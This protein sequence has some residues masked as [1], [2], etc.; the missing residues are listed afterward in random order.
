[1]ASLTSRRSIDT[2]LA[3]L[4]DPAT[5]AEQPVLV[6]FIRALQAATSPEA[7]YRL[8]HDLLIRYLA[9]QRVREGDLATERAA[10]GEHFAGLVRADPKPVDEIRAVQARIARIEHTDRVM[11]ALAAHLRAIADGLVW[12]ATGYDRVAIATLSRGTR[13]DRLADDGVGLQAELAAL[14]ELWEEDHAFT[15]HN[16][17]T[18]ILRHGDLTTFRPEQRRVEIREIKAGRPA[19]PT[20]PQVARLSAAT[21]LINEAAAT[22]PETGQSITLHR[23][24]IAYRTSLSSLDDAIA[25]ARVEGYASRSISEMQ[26]LTV[27]DYRVWAGREEELGEHHHASLAA[28]GWGPEQK[29]FEWM[30]ALRRIR[31][32]RYS[33]GGLA[34]LAIFPASPEDIAD[35]MLG[36]LEMHTMLRCDVL[37][38]KFAARGIDATADYPDG[39][40]R[41]LRARRG[42]TQLDIPPHLREQMLIELM[43]PESLVDIAD[44]MLDITAHAPGLELDFTVGCDEHAAW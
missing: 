40:R 27:I 21:Q 41:F 7:L 11:T 44:A 34:P 20:S 19:S 13:V 25:Q 6:E 35:L 10:A 30:S 36:P 4:N 24:P 32:R 14:G 1:M 38:A 16:D 29:T 9:R 15:I 33:F 43:T 2:E 42:A 26:Q 12:K 31:D 8:H 17:L 22:D 5:R 39:D 23:L 37:E 3:V 18:T 28:L